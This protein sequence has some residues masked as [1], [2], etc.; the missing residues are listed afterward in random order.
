MNLLRLDRQLLE[1]M[2]VRGLNISAYSDRNKKQTYHR[3][4]ETSEK[5]NRTPT[6]R[7][8]SLPLIASTQPMARCAE[9]PPTRRQGPAATAPIPPPPTQGRGCTPKLSNATPTAWQR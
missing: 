8:I 2:A 7:P 1:L 4:R 3:A 6:P 9:I 5:I